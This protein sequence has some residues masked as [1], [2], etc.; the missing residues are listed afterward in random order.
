MLMAGLACMTQP[1]MGQ[2]VTTPPTV[3]PSA[4]T[5][6]SGRFPEPC[7]EEPR[8]DRPAPAKNT[9]KAKSEPTRT[10]KRESSG[11][12]EA[13]EP[14][15]AGSQTQ[16]PS[17][18]VGF[19]PVAVGHSTTGPDASL[20]STR[21]GLGVTAK[22]APETTPAPHDPTS[23][24]AIPWDL[25]RAQ[26]R[27]W[28]SPSRVQASDTTWMV[29]F[30]AATAAFI[31]SDTRI[32]Q[33]LPS[34]ANTINNADKVSNYLA[35]SMGGITGAAYLFGRLEHNDHLSETGLLAG[36]AALTSLAPVYL[37]KTLAGRARPLE[38]DGKGRFGQGGQSFPSEHSAAA[39]SIASV[40]ASE[41]PNPFVDLLA[42]GSASAISAGRV[43]ARQHFTSD[44][45][46]GAALGWFV[47]RQTYN[48]RRRADSDRMWGTFVQPT[49][50]PIRDPKYM[51]SAYVPVDSWIY[52]AFDRL[53][54]LGYL[55]SGFM[56]LRP[57]SRMECARLVEEVAQRVPEGEG[58]PSEAQSIYAK[59]RVEFGDEIGRRAGE[60]NQDATV[61]SVYS[62]Y[63]G[64]AGKPLTDGYHF[65]QTITNDFG[66]LYGE[67]SN[68]VSGFA[69]RAAAGPFG[70]Y[71]RGEFQHSASV[72]AE[73]LA[74]REA[75]A[76]LDRVP[77]APDTA[78]PSRDRLRTMEAYVALNVHNFQFSFGKQSLW[79]G[80]TAGGP[81]MMSDNAEGINMLR[82]SQTQPFKLPSILG[83]L[84]PLRTEFF[85]GQLSGYRFVEDFGDYQ[86]FL[87][88]QPYLF[89]Q[90]I[91][92]K[93]TPNFEF[94]FSR[95]TIF[96]GPDSPFTLHKLIKILGVTNTSDV[97]RPR[98]GPDDPGDRRSGFDFSYRIPGLRDWLILY[99]DSFVDDEF[100]PVAYP[101]RAGWN[102]GIYVPKF[103]HLHRLDFRAEGETTPTVFG[104]PG[105]FYYNVTYRSGYTNDGNLLGNWV[106]RQGTGWQGWSTYWLSP[107]STIQVQ[108]R[109]AQ[110]D[111]ELLGGGRLHDYGLRANLQIRSDLTL[112]GGMQYETWNFPLLAP[113]SQSN[114]VT[115]FQLT[116]FPQW[117]VK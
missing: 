86:S 109:D 106:G 74:A 108:Y 21:E 59:L 82:M 84:G 79:W 2:N 81:M 58:R 115:S 91:S 24:R 107:M 44:V 73:P 46:I 75:I 23:F 54:A 90:K 71:F 56:G 112:S 34:S 116:F 98:L 52:P 39:W 96:S 13:E 77:L 43:I 5:D 49:R 30:A 102:P 100:S 55:Q 51:G 32:E 53:A 6:L 89:G 117:K 8:S 69:S 64:I 65:G 4:C 78:M 50:E 25:V 110:V 70:F 67:G 99:T 61:E 18:G 15:T 38:G 114:L 3:Q 17:N 83:W 95:T 68:S 27:F 1:A 45:V 7:P 63:L 40:V 103:P 26:K 94:G 62:R 33:S 35:Y 85:L 20:S 88:P 36:E 12:P 28:I 48:A 37:T 22:P 80:P 9:H 104:F 19:I 57:W 14:S 10:E 11:N 47:G 111:K 76:K 72:P 29:P 31:A 87:N 101:R 60:R 113:T 105:F 16:Q 66:R 97:G 92:F 93:P 41:Y 42:Y